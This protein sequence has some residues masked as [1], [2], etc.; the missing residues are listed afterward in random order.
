MKLRIIG[1]TGATGREIVS[2]AL[3]VG[4]AVTVLVRDSGKASFA[5][6]V[7]KTMGDVLVPDTLDSCYRR[8]A[9]VIT[10]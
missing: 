3:T 10:Y 1:A 8:Q 2:H 4:H 6:S 5:G 9:P 7:E